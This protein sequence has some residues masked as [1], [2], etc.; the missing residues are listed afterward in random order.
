MI[1]LPISYSRKKSLFFLLP[2]I[3]F[4]GGV[5]FLDSNLGHDYAM[6]ASRHSQCVLTG[7]HL[8][9]TILLFSEILLKWKGQGLLSITDSLPLSSFSAI[10]MPEMISQFRA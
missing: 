9:V 10:H 3:Y 2:S 6:F 4:R 8:G 7:Q 5:F 1:P